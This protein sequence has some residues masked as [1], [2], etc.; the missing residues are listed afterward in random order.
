MSNNNT[1]IENNIEEIHYYIDNT[2]FI[3]NNINFRRFINEEFYPIVANNR[4]I[5][6]INLNIVDVIRDGNCLYRCIFLFVYV[7]EDLHQ[8]VLNEISNEALNRLNEYPVITIDTEL[9][10]M[11]LRE[12]V[13]HINTLGVYGSELEIHISSQIYNINIVTYAVHSNNRGYSRYFN[14]TEENRN[15]LILSNINNV[16]FSLG[17]YISNLVLDLNH[18]IPEII[19]ENKEVNIDSCITKNEYNT[20]ENNNVELYEDIEAIK[21][22]N[23]F[24]KIDIDTRIKFYTNNKNNELG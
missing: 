3:N 11:L 4:S 22:L 19:N 6:P 23:D 15:L 10:P 7:T 8:R 5:N 9:G 2:T 20:L 21:I 18:N 1:I 17:Y 14:N 24:K 16:H 13:N 12:Y